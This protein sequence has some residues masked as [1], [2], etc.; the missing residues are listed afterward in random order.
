MRFL[1]TTAP[2]MATMGRNGFPAGSSL[3]RDLGST[4]RIISTD[5]STIIS[6]FARATA[7]LCPVEVS[8]RRNIVQNFTAKPCMTRVVVKPRV[9]AGSVRDGAVETYR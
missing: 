8:V 6:T 9:D 5:M 4:V 1:L 2:Q 3:E 7:A